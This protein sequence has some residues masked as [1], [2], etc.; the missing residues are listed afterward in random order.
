MRPFS[1]T[2]KGCSTQRYHDSVTET[3]TLVRSAIE[4]LRRTMIE[5]ELKIGLD[6]DGLARLRVSPVIARL[7]TEPG[8]TKTLVSVYYDTPGHALAAAGRFTVCTHVRPDRRR[9]SEMPA[10][11]SACPGVS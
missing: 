2:G 7:R 4:S 8:K 6:E 5:A 1:S 3:N 9:R 10:A 11:A